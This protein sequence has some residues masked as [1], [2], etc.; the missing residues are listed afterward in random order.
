MSQS[1]HEGHGRAQLAIE[2]ECRVSIA[3]STRAHK[4][5][6]R[7]LPS[8]FGKYENYLIISRFGCLNKGTLD[9]VTIR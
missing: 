9:I 6:V 2:S 8:I 3:T 7:A 4:N 1:D 5:R